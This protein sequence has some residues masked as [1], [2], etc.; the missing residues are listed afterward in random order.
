M[1]QQY[2]DLRRQVK[3]TKIKISDQDKADL[4]DAGGYNEFRKRNFGRMKLGNDGISIDSLYQELSGQH[5]ELFPDSITHPADQLQTIASAL[6]QTDA[7]V[8]NP[9]HANMDEMA[10]I[11]GQDILQSYFD[12]RSEKP[13]FAD[14]KAAEVQRVKRTYAQKMSEYK[15]SIKQKYEQ[16]LKTIRKENLDKVQELA[17][18]Y[19]NLSEAQQR[20]QKDYYK[21]K[22]DALRNEKTRRWQ[23]CK[24]ET[25]NRYRRYVKAR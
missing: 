13:T 11:V 8:D 6:E 21:S 1:T 16:E 22:M 2:K 23:Q 3:N 9:Y 10:Y 14:R 7:Q 12:V 17:K 5:P 20:E 25:V 18:I 15:S 24:A 19:R 4:A